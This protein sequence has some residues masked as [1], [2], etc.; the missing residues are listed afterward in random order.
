MAAPQCFVNDEATGLSIA[1]N[2]K[3]THIEMLL[4]WYDADFVSCY[5]TIWY[6]TV[7]QWSS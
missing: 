7:A 4:W 6:E 2:E 1:A 5:S 3:N